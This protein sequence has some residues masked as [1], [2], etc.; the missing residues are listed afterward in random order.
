MELYP[1]ASSIWEDIKNRNP[2]LGICLDIGHDLRA[3]ADPIRD[4][5]RFGKRVY[6]IHL[7]DV[8]APTKAGHAIEL[9]RG[10]IDFPAF[11]KMLRKV[12]YGGSVS[13]EYV[14]YFKAVQQ[15]GK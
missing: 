9:G 6:D 13:L 8:T 10:I 12:G 15:V 2:R 1:D 14:G 7:K 5:K 4:L 3:G 11:V